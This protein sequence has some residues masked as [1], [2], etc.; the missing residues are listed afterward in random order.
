METVVRSAYTACAYPYCLA[1]ERGWLYQLMK[2]ST[3]R[4]VENL[5]GAVP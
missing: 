5:A 3:L 1:P 4:C 2:E